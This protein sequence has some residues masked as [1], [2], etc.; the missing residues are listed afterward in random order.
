MPTTWWN[1]RSL[2]RCWRAANWIYPMTLFVRKQR[3]TQWLPNF[4]S[5]A[6]PLA[7]C[8]SSKIWPLART[9]ATGPVSPP[10]AREPGGTNHPTRSS[11]SGHRGGSG[12]LSARSRGW[13]WPTWTSYRRRS[14]WA[15]PCLEMRPCSKRI[16]LE[17]STYRSPNKPGRSLRTQPRPPTAK[18]GLCSRRPP[19]P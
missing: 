13:P 17:T 7:R 1:A 2:G 19:W 10:S 8:D 16:P 11:S 18:P 15:P 6:P 5:F 4:G 3:S 9:A 14:R 12:V